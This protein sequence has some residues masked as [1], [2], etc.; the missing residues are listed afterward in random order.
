MLFAGEFVVLGMT[1]LV[2]IMER[3]NVKELLW[4]PRNAPLFSEDEE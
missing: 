4:R 3:K 1:C 2:R